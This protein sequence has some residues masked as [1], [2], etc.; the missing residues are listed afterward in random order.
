MAAVAVNMLGSGSVTRLRG[1]EPARIYLVGAMRVVAPG[2][3]DLLP[4][5]RKTRALL[6]YIC[7]A[8]GERIPRSRLLGL[9]WDRSAE[10]QARMSLRHA[11]SELNDRLNHR[12][13]ELIEIDRE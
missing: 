4:R 13:P 5:A 3:E 9:L 8:Q 1:G 6:A 12:V 10:A 11:L 2:G 7:L